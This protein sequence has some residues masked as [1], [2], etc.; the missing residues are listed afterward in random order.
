[1]IERNKNTESDIK[2]T[3]LKNEYIKKVKLIA[4]QQ[5]DTDKL[6][7]QVAQGEIKIDSKTEEVNYL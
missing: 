7:D 4:T 5:D 2:M 3:V 1:M 6:I